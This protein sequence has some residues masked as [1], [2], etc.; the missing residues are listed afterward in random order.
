MATRPDSD[1]Q[2]IDSEDRADA[3]SM[4]NREASGLSNQDGCSPTNQSSGNDP[5]NPDPEALQDV[6]TDEE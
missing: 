4:T 1:D 2:S 3:G 5:S 6:L